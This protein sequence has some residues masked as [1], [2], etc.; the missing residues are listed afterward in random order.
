M[1]IHTARH[2]LVNILVVECPRAPKSGAEVSVQVICAPECALAALQVDVIQMAA[3]VDAGLSVNPQG[4]HQMS[5]RPEET[6]AVVDPGIRQEV[7][8]LC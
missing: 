5:G 1:V 4:E 3:G 8:A 7:E 6:P 2:L